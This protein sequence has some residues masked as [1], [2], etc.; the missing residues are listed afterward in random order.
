MH[1]R[2]SRGFENF[3]NYT[4]QKNFKRKDIIKATEYQERI[5]H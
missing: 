5:D 4:P 3:Q 1:I 2:K